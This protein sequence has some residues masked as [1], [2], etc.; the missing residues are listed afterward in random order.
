MTGYPG[1]P[2]TAT[3]EAVLRLAGDAVRVEWAINEK[4]AFDTAFGASLA[5]TR[6]LVCLKSV[7]LNVALDSLMVANLAAGD[8]GF[9]IL[10]G[11]DPGGWGSQNEQ[12]SRPLVAAAEVPL[13][14]P[15][16]VADARPIMRWAFELSECF[17][18][19]VVVRITQALAAGRTSTC[20]PPAAALSSGSP[21]LSASRIVSTSCRSMWSS[22]TGACRPPSAGCRA[23]L[24]HRPGIS[25]RSCQPGRRRPRSGAS[26]KGILAAGYAYQKLADVLAQS[27]PA[28][29]AHP[30]PEH[31]LSA[32]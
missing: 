14:E 13:L 26:R 20:P 23:S 12:D 10:T 15:T 17:Q 5:G 16:A 21:A 24:K 22:I 25:E 7:G 27:R 19:P 18:V 28:S 2:S 31:T 30:A 32:P 6:S 3:L 4:S 8:G 9:V 11:D 29:P 1:S